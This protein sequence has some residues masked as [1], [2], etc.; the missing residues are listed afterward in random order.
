MVKIKLKCFDDEVIEVE[1]EV[2][3]GCKVIMQCIEHS[4]GATEGEEIP[5]MNRHCTGSVVRELLR[6]MERHRED[7]PLPTEEPRPAE[8]PDHPHTSL[9]PADWGPDDPP[10]IGC[11][12]EHTPIPDNW[13][14]RMALRNTDWDT[15][16]IEMAWEEDMLFSMMEASNYL[17]HQ[18]LSDCFTRHFRDLIGSTKSQ[19]KL[20]EMFALTDKTGQPCQPTGDRG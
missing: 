5:L 6:W 13:V 18:S 10:Q 19:K 1:E 4:G 14:N 20:I 17:E 7:P 12:E 9:R 3:K 16:W 8:D 2:I 11:S 15:Q